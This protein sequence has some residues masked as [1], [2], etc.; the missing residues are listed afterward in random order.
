VH[1]AAYRAIRTQLGSTEDVD[2]AKIVLTTKAL[3]DAI[4]EFVQQRSLSA[5]QPTG[6]DAS[7]SDWEDVE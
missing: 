5:E 1:E 4:S 6:S 3:T 7:G 2:P